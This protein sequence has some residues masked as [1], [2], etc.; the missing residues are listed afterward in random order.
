MTTAKILGCPWCG[1]SPAHDV[2]K[3]RN[4]GEPYFVVKLYCRTCGAGR[5]V[6]ASDDEHQLATRMW[7]EHKKMTHA[8]L[9]AHVVIRDRLLALWNT[10]AADHDRP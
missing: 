3:H 8:E 5:A 4:C 6:V 2:I 10:R 9:L 7:P 1:E